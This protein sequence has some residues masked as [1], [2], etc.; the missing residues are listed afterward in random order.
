[1]GI[2]LASMRP[3]FSSFSA[4]F[5]A[6]SW[7]Q[8][9]QFHSRF[10]PMLRAKTLHRISRPVM[11]TMFVT[12]FIVQLFSYFGVLFFPS[13][14]EFCESSGF[15]LPAAATRFYSLQE[16][17]DG[18][19][20]SLVHSNEHSRLFNNNFNFM[21]PMFGTEVSFIASHAV[22]THSHYGGS[23][24]TFLHWSCFLFSGSSLCSTPLFSSAGRD[25]HSLFYNCVSR[26][27]HHC[28]HAAEALHFVNE[29]WGPASIRD[30]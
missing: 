6:F 18:P 12:L 17:S 24:S 16:L 15:S 22:A 4:F 20:Y 25:S 27:P 13:S 1:M 26:C 28:L 19:K 21:V 10:F 2:S 30:Y 3:V 11:K 7:I 5:Q 9:F 23:T 8:T 29:L 14:C